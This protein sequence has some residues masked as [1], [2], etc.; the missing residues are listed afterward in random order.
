M[1]PFQY[2]C[3]IYL[4]QRGWDDFGQIPECTYYGA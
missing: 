2:G 3:Q 4:I 1:Y